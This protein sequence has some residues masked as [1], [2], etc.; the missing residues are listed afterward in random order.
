ML[1]GTFSSQNIYGQGKGEATVLKSAVPDANLAMATAQQN[2]LREQE[3]K[4]EKMIAAWDTDYFPLVDQLKADKEA[5]AKR[6]ASGELTPEKAAIAYSKRGDELVS[7]GLL[8][9]KQEKDWN[10]VGEIYAKDDKGLYNVTEGYT[11]MNIYKD[12]QKYAQAIPEIARQLES[13]GGDKIMWRA[14]YGT[15]FLQPALAYDHEKMVNDQFGK[16]EE[17][18]TANLEALKGIA[19]MRGVTV[20]EETNYNTDA[21]IFQGRR[22]REQALTGNDF[23]AQKY[24][25]TANGYINNNVQVDP[26]GNVKMTPAG[27]QLLNTMAQ[28]FGYDP[29]TKTIMTGPGQRQELTPELLQSYLFDAYN[30]QEGTKLQE[31]S[32]K[33]NATLRQEINNNIR[34]PGGE[35]KAEE[36]TYW[37]DVSNLMT[38][39]LNPNQNLSMVGV[40]QQL[41][42]KIVYKKGT[43]DPE[44]IEIPI[45]SQLSEKR[46]SIPTQRAIVSD[47]SKLNGDIQGIPT[48]AVV[49]FGTMDADGGFNVVS[50]AEYNN[51]TPQQRE[52]VTQFARVVFKEYVEPPKDPKGKGKEQPKAP[53]YVTVD[54]NLSQGSAQADELNLLAPELFVGGRRNTEESFGKPGNFETNPKFEGQ[55]ENYGDIFND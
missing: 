48:R 44:R 18:T 19:G 51:M 23:K 38:T 50:E 49:Q 35:R 42:G 33:I 4:P 25:Q 36:Q 30:I 12:P 17:V 28:N 20:T 13:V 32:S 21:V 40:A 3:A 41:N 47:G 31:R 5:I 54:Y 10:A 24:Y 55:P 15:P 8:T 27:K 43:D 14:K 2:K 6:V 45:P 29:E 39:A 34:L 26:S 53:R 37:G 22:I 11:N 52:K 16:I 9:Q 7:L 1:P 46:V